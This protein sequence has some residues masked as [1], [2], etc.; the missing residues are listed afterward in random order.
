MK[1]PP[2]RALSLV[3]GS[4]QDCLRDLIPLHARPNPIILDVT[5]GAGRIWRRLPWQPVERVDCRPLPNL[6][7][8]GDFCFLPL[9]WSA[10]FDIVVFDPPH[11]TEAGRTSR[12]V[13]RFGA[14]VE[15]VQHSADIVHL[16]R[17][18]LREAHRVL[19]P[20]GVVLAKIGDQVHR[21]VMR[22]Q[23]V[24]FVLAARETPGLTA[25]D[26]QIK[27]EPR[28][29]TLYGHNWRIQRHAR[30]AEVFWLVVRKGGCY[31]PAERGAVAQV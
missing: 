19:K 6:T 30:R 16:Y 22:W 1:T 9:E 3:H 14:S 13:E 12:Y 29:S 15:T 17:P 24:D 20:G 11:I 4:D 26:R 8:V 23:V 21:G 27:D 7:W 31:R 18:F 25:C 5:Y 10:R 2:G 28:A